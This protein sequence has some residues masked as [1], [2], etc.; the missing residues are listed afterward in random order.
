LSAAAFVLVAACL[1]PDS[2]VTV[3]GVG[4]NPTRTG[5]LDA[6]QSMGA[7]V[8]VDERRD[9]TGEPVGSVTAEHCQLRG[10]ELRDQHVVR[11]IDEI[12]I[13]AVAATQA[14][15]E[16]VVRDAEELHTKESDRIT[17][18]VEELRKMGARMEASPDGFRVEGPTRLH[19][20]N[21]DSH[22]DHRLGM[23]LAVAGLIAEGETIIEPA[24]R[25]GDSF[26]GFASL[27]ATLGADVT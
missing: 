26:P 22:G 7:T 16:S 11:M 1:V 21:V 25:I 15:G 24:W 23:A 18:L 9:S 13:F 12:P 4:I 14:E 5:L 8:R 17:A 3:V 2:H 20:A 19:G 10:V 27:L 6:L